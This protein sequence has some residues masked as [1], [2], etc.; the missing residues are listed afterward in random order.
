LS[1]ATIRARSYVAH[2]S[3]P[4]TAQTRSSRRT[5]R[6]QSHTGVVIDGRIRKAG[7][8]LAYGS[9]GSPMSMTAYNAGRSGAAARAILQ[10]LDVLA[11]NANG[12]VEQLTSDADVATITFTQQVDET[13]YVAAGKIQNPPSTG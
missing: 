8:T 4:A 10:H 7:V 12:S 9:R 2:A 11:V 1:S 13:L 6:R 3:G 5:Q